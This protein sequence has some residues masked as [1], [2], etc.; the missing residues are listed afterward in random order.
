MLGLA[1]QLLQGDMN[2]GQDWVHRCTNPP[3]WMAMQPASAEEEE[4]H[5]SA[6]PRSERA[7]MYYGEAAASSPSSGDIMAIPVGMEAIS[8]CGG[9]E[10]SESSAVV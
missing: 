2:K 7:F 1:V 6:I 4:A 3:A 5:E 9:E 10:K 8:W